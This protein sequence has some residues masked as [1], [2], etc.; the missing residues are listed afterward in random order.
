MEYRFN[1]DEWQGLAQSQR[2][3]RCRLMAEE[4][5]KLSTHASPELKQLYLGLAE[6]WSALASELERTLR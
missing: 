2:I 6:K 4:A 1:S 3:Y 5:R